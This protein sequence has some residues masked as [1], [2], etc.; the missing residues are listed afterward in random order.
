MLKKIA[1]TYCAA[2]GAPLGE[3]YGAMRDPDLSDRKHAVIYALFVLGYAPGRIARVFR[4]RSRTSVYYACHRVKT[5]LAVG[6]SRMMRHTETLNGL[7]R[8]VPGPAGNLSRA[9]RS[10]GAPGNKKRPR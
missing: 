1:R 6:D 2:L 3:L 4:L 5:L 8:A 9:P 10:K 7:G